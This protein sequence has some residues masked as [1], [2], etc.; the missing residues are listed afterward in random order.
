M[1]VVSVV[2]ISLFVFVSTKIR[3]NFRLP[4]LFLKI[5]KN[6]FYYNDYVIFF[7]IMFDLVVLITYLFNELK[8]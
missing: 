3:V 2:V 5:F 6:I 4:N 7:G 1:V 8:N